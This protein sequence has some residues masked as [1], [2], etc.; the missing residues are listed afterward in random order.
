MYLFHK[1]DHSTKT[2]DNFLPPEDALVPKL[3]FSPLFSLTPGQIPSL[4]HPSFSQNL[5]HS[6]LWARVKM[7]LYPTI[8]HQNGIIYCSRQNNDF[9]KMFSSYFLYPVNRLLLG[10]GELVLEGI[11]VAKQWPLS[12]PWIIQWAPYNHKGPLH[13]EGGGRRLSDMMWETV[14]WTL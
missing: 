11:Q 9:P 2:V 12:L 6:H 8:H 5:W 1:S 13:A 3:Q 7:S 10:E 14:N 4:Y